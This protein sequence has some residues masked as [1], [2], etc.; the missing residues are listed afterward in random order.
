VTILGREAH[1][2]QRLS[3][4]LRIVT[5]ILSAITTARGVSDKIFGSDAAGPL[6][7]FTALGI[8]TTAAIGIEAAFKFEKRA[9][10]LNMLSAS[11]QATAIAVDSEW[12][13]NIGS[14]HD[15]DLRSAARDLLTMQD[16]TLAEIHQKGAAAGISVTLAVRKLDDP[17]DVPYSA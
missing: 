17:S 4:W 10:D 15:T 16:T 6:L 9:A 3:N 1:R 13:K 8:V 11:C 5:I 12:R 7:I 2:L 14:I